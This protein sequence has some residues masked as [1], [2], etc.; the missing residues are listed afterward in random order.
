MSERPPIC[1]TRRGGRCCRSSWFRS[2]RARRH[3]RV[4]VCPTATT[5][6]SPTNRRG[7]ARSRGPTGTSCTA[8]SP[9]ST[10][11]RCWS[12]P[13]GCELSG[14]ARRSYNVM[15]PES[16]SACHLGLRRTMN[17]VVEL[18]TLLVDLERNGTNVI[19]IVRDG[20]SLVPWRL[21]PGD[22]GIFDRRTHSQCY[23]HSHRLDNE[24][25]HF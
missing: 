5:T 23:Y 24:A 25:G 21:Y 19:D 10:T 14:R 6:M 15:Y 18:R 9:C 4:A 11:M 22:S 1:S 13:T 8:S 16:A 3:C 2:R 7:T 17:A 12:A 20:Q